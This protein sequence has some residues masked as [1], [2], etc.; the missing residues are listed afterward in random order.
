MSRKLPLTDSSHEDLTRIEDLAPLDHP[1][2]PKLPV[3]NPPEFTATNIVLSQNELPS[4]DKI[5]VHTNPVLESPIQIL[6]D[7]Q[8]SVSEI[9]NFFQEQSVDPVQEKLIHTE[10]SVLPTQEEEIFKD[11]KEEVETYVLKHVP[12]DSYPSY[13]LLIKNIL[14]GPQK[15]AV[16]LLLKEFELFQSDTEKQLVQRSL[17]RGQLLIPRISEFAAIYFSNK[18]E[19]ENLD[20]QMSPSQDFTEHHEH[21]DVGPLTEESFHHR[22]EA[23]QVIQSNSTS[24][25]I[26]LT[27]SF[28]IPNMKLTLIGKLLQERVEMVFTSNDN[29]SL[30]FLGDKIHQMKN[31]A[32]LLG[33]NAIVGITILKISTDQFLITGEAALMERDV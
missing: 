1:P 17:K 26:F 19:L 24:N 10:K 14:R 32:I 3:E 23:G 27:Q 21:W 5:E 13:S 4:L 30:E 25:D 29:D 20:I 18:L 6:N 8:T 28:Y 31:D 16:E 11:I 9:N 7:S 22:H 33:A 2:L 15:K 12:F